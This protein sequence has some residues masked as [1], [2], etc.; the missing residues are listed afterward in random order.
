MELIVIDENKLKIMLTAP[1]MRHY[2][3][4]AERVPL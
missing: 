4:K 3:L 1:D 2:D